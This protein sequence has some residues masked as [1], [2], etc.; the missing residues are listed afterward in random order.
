[1]TFDTQL[2]YWNRI[3]P[4]KTFAH[5]VNIEKLSRWVEPDSRI[6]DYGCGYGRALGLL[7][8]KGYRNL[9][10]M[11]PAAAMID[12]AHTSY[13]DIAFAFLN[14]FHN[15]A[16]PAGS[17]DA[18]LLFAVLTSVPRSEDQLAI[19]AEITRV[20]RPGGV[21]YI[22]DMWLQTDARNVARYVRDQKKYGV[23]GVFDLS[24]GATVRH[25]DRQW[26]DSLLSNYDPVVLDE[27]EVQTMNGN[28]ATAFQWFG[29]RG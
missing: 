3:G 8:S 25:H 12:A 9:I 11:D 14:D 4:S 22:S 6:L 24:D 7:Q 28:P 17:I 16:L 23:Y 13:P 5:P 27:I 26:I 21:L 29:L 2:D 15:T 18:V 10:G 1:V 20:L 19:V